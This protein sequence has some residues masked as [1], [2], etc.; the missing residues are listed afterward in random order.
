[1][2]AGIYARVSVKHKN[3][4]ELS[5]EGQILLARQYL[6]KTKETWNRIEYFLDCGY[7]GQN[8][9]RPGFEKMLLKIQMGRL[10]CIV[11]KDFS[12]LGRNYRMVG[13]Y[14]DRIFPLWGIRLLSITE[15]FDSLTYNGS[16]SIGIG[17]LMNEWYAK[18]IGKKVSR[19]KQIQREQGNYLGSL[20]PYGYMIVRKGERRLLKRA[21]TY[22]VLQEMLQLDKQGLSST[23]IR[24]FLYEE[25]INP[26]EM[27]QKTGRIREKYQTAPLWSSGT[28]RRILE[29]EKRN[30]RGDY[31]AT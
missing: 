6:E 19:L 5:M 2:N 29:R 18:D 21:E 26:P 25:R 23:E 13:Q 22:V 1:M 11:I 20:P 3:D 17:N 14:V 7:S 9:H 30:S 24:D 12:R 16:V 27:Y 28:I 10:D 15:H 31:Y 4:R 8:F